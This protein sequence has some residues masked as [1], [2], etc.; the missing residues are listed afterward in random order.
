MTRIGRILIAFGLLLGALLVG[1][2]SPAGAATGYGASFATRLQIKIQTDCCF[3]L[4]AAV[5]L[6]VSSDATARPSSNRGGS[7][8]A[9]GDFTG[10]ARVLLDG[11]LIKEVPVGADGKA[12]FEIPFNV[13]KVGSHVVAAEYVPAS[14]SVYQGSS[15][16]RAF[17][18][19]HC[20]PGND[21][22]LPNTG[23]ILPTTGGPWLGIIVIAVL[24]LLL[25]AWL[26]RRKNSEE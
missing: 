4:P 26:M 2:T 15:A 21:D 20:H 6:N 17:N 19:I 10:S 22:K 14:D 16:S 1:G 8:R 13:L 3:G 24:L 5:E 25:G 23:G 11:K 12:A 7:F 18:V 9:I